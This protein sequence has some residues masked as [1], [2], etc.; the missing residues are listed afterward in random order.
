M[1]KIMFFDIDGTLIPEDGSHEVPES[2]VR[3]LALAKAAGNLLFVNTGRPAVN[4]GDDVRS[5]GF[6]GYIYGCGTNIECDG[7]E[8]FYSTV[9]KRICTDT[10]LMIRKCAASPMYERRDCVLFDFRARMLPMITDI[11]QSFAAQG[12]NV[13]KSVDDS[14]FS[15][16]KFIICFDEKTDLDTLRPYIEQNFSWIDRGGGFAELVPYACSKATGIDRVLAYYGIDKADSYAIGD[17]LNDL[18][19]LSAA[20]TSIAMGNGKMLIPYADHVTDDIYAD[21]IYNA[22]EK[23]GFFG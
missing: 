6:D 18:P 20:G 4:V 13:D 7:K 10:A 9:E 16:D 22:L 21:G 5:L 2:T 3:A 12:K 15:F 17:S 8:I 23:F 19:M 11:R 1:K 14:D